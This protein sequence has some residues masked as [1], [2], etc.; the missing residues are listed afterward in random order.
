MNRLRPRRVAAGSDAIALDDRPRRL[1]RS[2]ERR[3][4]VERQHGVDPCVG[5]QRFE[6]GRITRS[7]RVADDVDRVAAAP[8][9]RQYPVEPRDRRGR[10]F[11]EPPALRGQRVGRENAGAA[12]IGQDREPLAVLLAGQRQR[13]DR[14]E[15]LG[16]CRDPQH[17]GAAERGIINAVAARQHAGMRGRRARTRLRAPGLQ[18]QH[19]LQPR[20]RARRRHEFAAMRDAL[21][22]KQDRAGARLGREI[23]EHVAEIDIGHVA[24]RDDM[25]K[26]DAARRRPIEH[27]GDHRAGLADKGDVAGRRREMREARV[28]PDAG[29]DQPDAVRADQPQQMGARGVEHGAAATRG[30]VRR[31]RRIRP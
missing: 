25:R 19:R 6:R 28:E 11:G 17:A 31:V 1:V 18:H 20:R 27:R 15:Q 4:A 26:A 30:P 10:Q 29:D 12:A 22:I 9:R 2:R 16:H 24:E 14:I 13:L 3:R 8:G 23:V 21:G 5:E 7:R